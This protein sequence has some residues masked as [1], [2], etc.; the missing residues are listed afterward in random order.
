MVWDF[1]ECVSFFGYWRSVC[2]GV[3]WWMFGDI[4]VLFF[5]SVRPCLKLLSKICICSSDYLISSNVMSS[6]VCMY[7][8]SCLLR[9]FIDVHACILVLGDPLLKTIGSS[10]LMSTS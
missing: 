3:F 10:D 7:A 2:F 9:L 1:I 4:N 6:V 8:T 5:C